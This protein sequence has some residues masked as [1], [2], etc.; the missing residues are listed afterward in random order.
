LDKAGKK[1]WDNLWSDRGIIPGIDPRQSGFPNYVNRRFHQLFCEIFSNRKTQGE[2]ILEIGCAGSLWLPYFAKEFG[3]KVYGI[4]YSEIGC[5][6]AREMLSSEEIECEIVVSDFL[7]PPK[8]FMG[9]YDVVISFGV[10]EHY[11]DTSRC[12]KAISRYLKPGGLM[13]TN[14]PNLMG[15]IGLVQKLANPDVFYKHVPLFPQNLY[16]A[17]RCNGLNVITCNYF[18]VANFGI[19]NLENLRGNRLFDWVISMRSWLNNA[20]WTCEK[21]VP[22]L[23]PNRWSSPYI[24]C[25][26]TK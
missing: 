20:I 9:K 26:A 23:K 1:Y 19:L 3:F 14:I 22:F 15:L 21:L 6:Q 25:V 12:I 13:I 5:Q 16:K 4:D 8:S 18:L 10:V 11:E 7:S 17:H 2:K 24:N